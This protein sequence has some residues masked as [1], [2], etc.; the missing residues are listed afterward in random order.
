[1][2]INER[3]QTTFIQKRSQ[4]WYI[5]VNIVCMTKNSQNIK[6][7]LRF[8]AEFSQKIYNEKRMV[9]HI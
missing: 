9:L 3:T 1:M 7:L 6:G 2:D 5:L 4:P 8:V